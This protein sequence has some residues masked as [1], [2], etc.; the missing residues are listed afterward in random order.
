MQALRRALELAPG[1]T[2]AEAL[3]GWALMLQEQYDEAMATFAH[4]LEK[5]PS[6]TLARVNVGYICLKK[7]IFGEAIEHLSR[8]I[9]QDSD[10]KATLYAHYYLGLV[11]LEREMFTDAGRLSRARDPAGP[12]P[13]GS[14][15][16]AG[17]RAL[18]RRP[19]GRSEAGLGGRSGRGELLTLVG[20]LPPAARAGQRGRGGATVFGGLVLLLLSLQAPPPPT[21]E[22]VQ[23]GRVTLTAPRSGDAAR[24]RARRS[25]PIAPRVWPGYRPPGAGTHPAHRSRPTPQ[26]FAKLSGG[27][28]PSWGVGLAMPGGRAIVVRAD[29]PD[30]L[31]ALKHELAHLAL[32]DAVRV[33]V[34]LWFDEGY[35]VVAAGE[36]DRMEALRLNLAVVRGAAGDLQAL[37]AA[38]RQSE[39]EAATAYALAGSAVLLLARSNPAQSLDAL[40][41]KLGA[42]TGFEEA[43]GITTGYT[44]GTFE[45]AW[46]K[47]LRRQYGWFVWLV[48]GGG[49]AILGVVVLVLARWRRRRDA[50]A[51]GCPGLGLGCDRRRAYFAKRNAGPD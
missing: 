16:R 31:G 38:L 26:A 50:P 15:L 44:L 12:Q 11:Y 46:Q 24:P 2:Q 7:R 47:D 8:V 10:R 21:W 17:P 42:G 25:R 33:R 5:E 14:P 35:A 29:A 9:R 40:F 45:R 4:V 36:W 13:G 34:P 39:S 32:H 19:A 48:A 6:N 1:E 43:V 27:R 3:L 30:P 51:A 41:A 28:V 23:V 37:D 49:W 22:Q 20:P 18:V